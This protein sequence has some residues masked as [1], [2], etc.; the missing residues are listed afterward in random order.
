L[1]SLQSL[2]LSGYSRRFFLA[3]PF[4]SPSLFFRLRLARRRKL[5]G[6]LPR[7]P[8]IGNLLLKSAKSF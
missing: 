6:L 8:L 3:L 7:A 4:C 1:L 5:K 2:C